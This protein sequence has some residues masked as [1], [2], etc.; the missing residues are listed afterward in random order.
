[1]FD[2]NTSPPLPKVFCNQ[3]SVAVVGPVL[4]A[5]QTSAV[6]ERWIECILDSPA[7]PQCQ[8]ALASFWPIRGVTRTSRTCSPR[9]A[10]RAMADDEPESGNHY[11]RRTQL[12]T[13]A[14][15]TVLYGRNQCHRPVIVP[16][17]TAQPGSQRDSPLRT[18]H[19]ISRGE[20]HGEAHMGSNAPQTYTAIDTGRHSRAG[21][22]HRVR[23]GRDQCAR[24]HR[25]FPLRLKRC[26][27]Q[28]H[29]R[30]RARVRGDRV[31]HQLLRVPDSLRGPKRWRRS[32]L[33]S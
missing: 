30:H 10:F 27:A 8:E 11:G 2:L 31:R 19:P 24:S 18:I 15:G 9:G 21:N 3:A 7:S 14:L 20:H 1:M 17:K 12:H 22:H 32:R 16:R 33:R 25:A 23:T 13:S 4:A 26:P 28:R 5:E 6:E 29:L